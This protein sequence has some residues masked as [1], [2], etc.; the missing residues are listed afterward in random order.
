MSGEYVG[1][2]TSLGELREDWA[3][4]TGTMRTPEPHDGEE[5]RLDGFDWPQEPEDAHDR[6]AVAS[7][8]SQGLAK[9]RQDMTQAADEQARGRLDDAGFLRELE[10]LSRTAG[11]TSAGAAD[12]R[13]CGQGGI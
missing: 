1:E 2:T 4:Q 6:A 8:V 7:L 12:R 9:L 13:L 3:A 5:I 11:R 10:D